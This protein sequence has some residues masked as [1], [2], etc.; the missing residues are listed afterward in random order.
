M[1]VVS[2]TD[3]GET[4][5]IACFSG[6]ATDALIMD[7]WNNEGTTRSRA[8]WLAEQAKLSEKSACFYPT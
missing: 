5:A 2:C 8:S 1:V 3:A 4:P 7:Y 6:T